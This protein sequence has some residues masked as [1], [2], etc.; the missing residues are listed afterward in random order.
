MPQRPTYEEIRRRP[1]RPPSSADQEAARVLAIMI[2]EI[3]R[4]RTA[5]EVA[6]QEFQDLLEQGRQETEFKPSLKR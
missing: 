4:P 3:N 5:Q 2:E 1:V 6:A